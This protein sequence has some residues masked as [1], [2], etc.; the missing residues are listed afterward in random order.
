MPPAASSEAEG[1]LSWLKSQLELRT[2]T[3]SQREVELDELLRAREHTVKGLE[4]HLRAALSMLTRRDVTIAALESRLAAAQRE[5]E[6]YRQRLTK[7]IQRAVVRHHRTATKPVTKPKK[8]ARAAHHSAR[9]KGK[10]KGA[11]KRR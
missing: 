7:L 10:R 9:K 8:P 5:T 4:E 3:L 2:H 11:G 6:D 1:Q